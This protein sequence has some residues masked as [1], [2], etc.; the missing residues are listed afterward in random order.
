MPLTTGSKQI[1][2][3]TNLHGVINE[4]GQGVLRV[5]LEH[6]I[7]HGIVG[8]KGLLHLDGVQGKDGQS[9]G[10][11]GY[12][13]LELIEEDLSLKKRNKKQNKSKQNKNN[14]DHQ[15]NKVRKNPTT[16]SNCTPESRMA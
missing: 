3:K 8:G 1:C 2:H 16:W 10:L 12:H 4:L 6:V 9:G 11:V 14:R 7:V 5:R 15:K 13:S